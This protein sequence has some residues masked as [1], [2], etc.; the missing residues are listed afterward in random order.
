[1]LLICYFIWLFDLLSNGP[2]ISQICNIFL[3]WIVEHIL[4][5]DI[6][7]LDDETH[8]SWTGHCPTEQINSVK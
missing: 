7:K 5:D 3:H 4:N 2:I 6:P 1:M 8:A